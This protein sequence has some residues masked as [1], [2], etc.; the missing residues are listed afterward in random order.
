MDWVTIVYKSGAKVHARVERL[1]VR[2][3]QGEV[4]A[5]EWE[6]MEPRPLAVGVAE[7]AAIWMG[8]V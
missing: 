5:M 6:R 7:V 8:K 1:T 2:A 3:V 4:V